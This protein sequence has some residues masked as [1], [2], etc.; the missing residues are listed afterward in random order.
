MNKNTSLILGSVFILTSG[1]IYSIERLS[2]TVHW[3]ALIKTAGSYPTIVEYSFFDNIFTPIFL[4]V[5]IVLL[6]ISLMKK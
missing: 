1:L 3:L 2:S 6:V 4:V 5:G